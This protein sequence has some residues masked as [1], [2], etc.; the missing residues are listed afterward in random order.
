MAPFGKSEEDGSLRD[1]RP[2]SRLATM[3]LSRGWAPGNDNCR[4]FDSVARKGASYFA[5]DDTIFG[6]GGM[7]SFSENGGMTPFAKWEE[8]DRA[9]ARL[10]T[11]AM[12]LHE[13]AP[14]LVEG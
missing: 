5:Q 14:D 3:W 7:T 4:S 6:D 9:A 8:A 1:C 10:P 13:G 11:H 12:R 2:K